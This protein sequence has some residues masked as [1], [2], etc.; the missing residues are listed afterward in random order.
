MLCWLRAN[1][2]L[3]VT[4]GYSLK[5]SNQQKKRKGEVAVYL[6]VEKG[7][8]NYLGWYNNFF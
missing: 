5:E 2:H 8:F 6:N 7:G 4:K 1:R 3:L